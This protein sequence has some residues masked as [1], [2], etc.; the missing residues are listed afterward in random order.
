MG[1]LYTMLLF[2]L[3]VLV[4]PVESAAQNGQLAKLSEVM[5]IVE[6]INDSKKLGVY[7]DDI[8][9]HVFVFL[10]SK[11]PR[12]KVQLSALSSLAITVSLS[13]VH[14][15]SGRT[16]GYSGYVFLRAI[17]RAT[18]IETKKNISTIVVALV[19][20]FNGPL[21]NASTRVKETLDRLLTDFAAE[22]YRDNP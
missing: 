16:I 22:W 10:R 3:L 12:L 11:L 13:N 21:R 15:K 1:R 14:D 2:A 5:I 8:E 9:N 17:R 20:S 19:L 6:N 4:V 7:E 18:I